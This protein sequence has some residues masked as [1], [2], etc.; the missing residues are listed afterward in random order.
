MPEC[1]KRAYPNTFE[2]IDATELRCEIPSLL[3][4]QSKHYSS[5]K[6]HTT[7][8]CLLAI[9]PNRSFIS[10]S[11]LFSGSICDRALFE[12][13]GIMDLLRDVPRGKSIMAD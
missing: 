13:S 2:I 12:Q 7:M 6:S 8:K 3:S 11:E 1:F 9:A 10:V 4:L 5:Y